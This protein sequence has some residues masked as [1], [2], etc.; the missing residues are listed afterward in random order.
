MHPCIL[1]KQLLITLLHK[2]PAELLQR[3][4]A[5]AAH[6]REAFGAAPRHIEQGVAAGAQQQVV[7][8]GAQAQLGEGRA[9][10]QSIGWPGLFIKRLGL[11]GKLLA[12]HEAEGIN[13]LKVGRYGP[14]DAQVEAI[15]GVGKGFEAGSQGSMLQRAQ[16]VVEVMAAL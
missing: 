2:K 8:A 10:E 14:A 9:Q 3:P 5:K 13:V 16:E 15:Y 7:Q 4:G 12:E 6:R 1:L 11:P